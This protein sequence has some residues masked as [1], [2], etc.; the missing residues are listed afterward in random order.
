[1]TNQRSL[2]FDDAHGL[3]VA[4]DQKPIAALRIGLKSRKAVVLHSNAASLGEP[5]VVERYTNGP[6]DALGEGI[7][8]HGERDL[9]QPRIHVQE[10]VPVAPVCSTQRHDV[11]LENCPVALVELDPSLDDRLGPLRVKK[12]WAAEARPRVLTSCLPS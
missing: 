5:R 10:P 8:D 1:M 6:G 12:T 3:R 4:H 2:H 9:A 11:T 7:V